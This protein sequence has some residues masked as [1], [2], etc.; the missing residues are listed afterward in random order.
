[1]KLLRLSLPILLLTSCAFAGGFGIDEFKGMNTEENSLLI[2]ESKSPDMSNCDVSEDGLSIERRKG[3]EYEFEVTYP[4]WT[5]KSF[6]SVQ[7]NIY[8]KLLVGYG[9]HVEAFD[10]AYSST[11]LHSSATAEFVWDFVEFQGNAY[12]TN[13]TDTVFYTDGNTKTFIPTAPKGTSMVFYNDTC[14]IANTSADHSSVQYSAYS[15]PT[16]WST[17]ADEGDGRSFSIADYGARVVDLEVLGNSVLILCSNVI[18]KAVGV[19]NPYQV[20]EVDKSVGCKSKGSVVTHLGVTYFLG[21]DGQYYRTD[22]SLVENISEDEFFE[23]FDNTALAQRTA[24]FKSVSSEAEFTTGISSHVSVSISPGSVVPSS[25]TKVY[26]ST[27]DWD[28]WTLVQIDS[29]TSEGSIKLESLGIFDDFTDGDSV[30]W[31]LSDAGS[32]ATAGKELQFAIADANAKRSL[33]D[34]FDLAEDFSIEFKVKFKERGASVVVYGYTE[35]PIGDPQ[36]FVHMNQAGNDTWIGTSYGSTSHTTLRTNLNQFYTLRLVRNDG[37]ISL[38]KNGA[39]VTS[40]GMQG[41]EYYG[42]IDPDSYLWIFVELASPSDVVVFDDFTFVDNSF[43]STG[44]ATSPIYDAVSVLPVWGGIQVT[45]TINSDIPI[46]YEMRTSTDASMGDDPAFITVTTTTA[47]SAPSKRYVQLRASFTAAQVNPIGNSIVQDITLPWSTTGYYISPEVVATNV[48]SWG[49]FEVGE[50]NIDSE[51]YMTYFTFSSNTVVSDANLQDPAVVTWTAQP[52]NA[53]IAVSTNTY[54]WG[55]AVYSMVSGTQTPSFDA[56]TFNWTSGDNITHDMAAVWNGERLYLGAMGTTSSSS[57]DTTFV[58]DPDL[59]SWWKYPSGIFPNAFIEWRN[60]FLVASSTSGVV[61]EMLEGDTDNGANIDA[62]W[63]TKYITAT[64]GLSPLISSLEYGMF[65]F[66]QQSSGN[67]LIDLLLNGNSTGDTFTLDQTG[68]DD[69]HFETFKFPQG[70]NAR[71]FQFKVYNE[72]GSD[73]GFHGLV[74]ETMEHP[75]K[76][77]VPQ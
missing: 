23:A 19:A 52:K 51:A 54:V 25:F 61:Y 24:S 43:Y 2:E 38:A 36:F 13:G 49:L 57:N 63:K 39:T 1:M 70:R 7:N 55:K 47:I 16:D 11:M 17:G 58:W 45:D 44:T 64:G 14:W 6:G 56:V 35:D 74:G 46:Q 60:K 66:D 62:Y 65:V 73:F 20:I 10:A 40:L 4:T 26:T 50:S 76:I 41:G 31:T 37:T 42:K 21:S 77:K 22:G 8:D 33:P 69:I 28:T 67:L 3:I 27:T 48:N 9:P 68:G 34:R 75:L 72:K 29:T 59:D 53:I 5:V 30:G 12:A 71:Y 32:I 18:M 15:D